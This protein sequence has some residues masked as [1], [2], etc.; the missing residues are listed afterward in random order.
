M[1][2][3]SQ[4]FHPSRRQ[5]APVSYR[6]HQHVR[7]VASLPWVLERL[8]LLHLRHSSTAAGRTV[9]RARSAVTA[10]VCAHVPRRAVAC[11]AGR[12]RPGKPWAVCAM[13]TGRA[14]AVDVGHVLLCNWAEHGFGPVAFDYIFI[15]SK[16]IQFLVNSKICVGFI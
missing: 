9:T 8:P 1:L 6:L 15:F 10:L 14:D 11:R 4:F 13:H 2:P 5:E 12:G 7:R 16:Y 3:L